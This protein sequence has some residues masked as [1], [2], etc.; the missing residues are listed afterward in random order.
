MDDRLKYNFLS[1]EKPVYHVGYSNDMV[2]LYNSAI[3]MARNEPVHM[4]QILAGTV[5]NLPGLM[6]SLELDME[7]SRKGGYMD[8]I[9]KARLRIREG[10]ESKVTVQEIA[11]ELGSSYS[12]FRSCS[13]NT[14]ASRRLF[15]SRT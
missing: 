9:N 6:Y 10:V 5:D 7:L 15:T 3:N 8:M 1:L 4:Q 12:N 14:L 11:A 13:R 2:H